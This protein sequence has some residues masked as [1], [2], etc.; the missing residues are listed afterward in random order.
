MRAL[1]EGDPDR[2]VFLC[3]RAAEDAAARGAHEQAA[4]CHE[5]ALEALRHA[6]GGDK[7]RVAL[8]LALARER[9]QAGDDARARDAYLDAATLARAFRD[10]KSL[11]EANAALKST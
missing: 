11:R 2:A 9:K 4:A 3:E 10:E 5:R 1:P 6:S 7:R 8:Q